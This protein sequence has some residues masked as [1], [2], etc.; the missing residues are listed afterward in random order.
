MAS[1][2]FGKSP[3]MIPPNL[4]PSSS[5]LRLWLLLSSALSGASKVA[6]LVYFVVFLP[7]PLGEFTLAHP[8]LAMTSACG[9]QQ[10]AAVPVSCILFLTCCLLQLSVFN[11]VF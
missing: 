6:V 8:V 3:A 2:K 11:W 4:F 1:V 5:L 9:V 7:F 10:T